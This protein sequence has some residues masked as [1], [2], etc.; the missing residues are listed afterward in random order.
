M[1]KLI[2][3]LLAL[4]LLLTGALFLATGFVGDT[5]PEEMAT[6]DLYE[7]SEDTEYH[8]SQMMVW[9]RFRYDEPQGQL[10][11]RAT[12]GIEDQGIV[13]AALLVDLDETELLDQIRDCTP[14]QPVLL[15]CVVQT[16]RSR[17]A[18]GLPDPGLDDLVILNDEGYPVLEEFYLV[19]FAETM[20]EARTILILTRAILFGSAALCLGLGILMFRSLSKKKSRPVL[21]PAVP[22]TPQARKQLESYQTLL[23]QGL[24]TQEEFDKKRHQILGQ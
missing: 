4:A 19:Y 23:D 5:S 10:W 21:Y 17:T 14:Y 22:M 16:E 12:V 13:T 6:T 15:D 20:S 9:E 1:K 8:I 24:I 2:F 18:D 7:L 11:F 3:V